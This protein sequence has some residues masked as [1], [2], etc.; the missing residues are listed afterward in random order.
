MNRRPNV[1]VALVLTVLAG[2]SSCIG[3]PAEYGAWRRYG[4]KE[5]LILPT[6]GIVK[7]QY[8]MLCAPDGR[9][10]YLDK[11]TYRL[12]VRQPDGS[13]SEFGHDL[14]VEPGSKNFEGVRETKR[15]FELKDLRSQELRRVL[16]QQPVI[17]HVDN[18]RLWQGG[19][20]IVSYQGA[21][22]VVQYLDKDLA[23]DHMWFDDPIYSP[24]VN[25]WQPLAVLTDGGT[26]LGTEPGVLLEYDTATG[27]ARRRWAIRGMFNEQRVIKPELPRIGRGNFRHWKPGEMLEIG[28]GTAIADHQSSAYYDASNTNRLVHVRD[29]KLPA[30][31]YVDAPRLFWPP[32][33]MDCDSKGLVYILTLTG[34]QAFDRKKRVVR[35]LH[36][37]MHFDRDERP[38]VLRVHDSILVVETDRYV[39]VFDLEHGRLAKHKTLLRNTFPRVFPQ[40]TRWDFRLEDGRVIIVG[41]AYKGRELKRVAFPLP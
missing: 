12:R 14:R 32:L 18:M 40:D 24:G 9:V 30:P 10:Y 8:L 23:L 29:K 15:T 16:R 4:A 22:R 35:P 7:N 27:K 38:W 25:R 21:R 5:P 2:S 36:P 28:E 37:G 33:A 26:L 6:Q 13:V 34:V 41:P 1:I 3:R 20:V 31:T 11:K 19:V 39:Y 17:I